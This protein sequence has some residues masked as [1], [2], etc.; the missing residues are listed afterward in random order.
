LIGF[1]VLVA[2]LGPM[3]VNEKQARV[4]AA[5]PNLP[6][7]AEYAFG[8]DS[9]GRDVFTT[10]ILAIPPTLRIGLI[11]GVISVVLGLVLGLSAGF[12]RGWADWLIRTFSDVL[13]AV[14]ALA[15][16][17]LIVARME[18][19]NIAVV[20]VIVGFLT[21]SGTARGIRSMV[22]SIR[23]R[24]YTAVARANGESEA[25]VLFREIMPNLLPIMLASFI[26]A[27]SMGIYTVMSLEVLGLG[28]NVIPSLG[29]MI[30]WSQRFSA[31]LRG[32]YWWWGPPIFTIALIFIGLFFLSF[33]LDRFINPAIPVRRGL[34]RGKRSAAPSGAAAPSA[35][36]APAEAAARDAVLEIRN[37]RVIY[38]TAGGVVK[39]VDDVS[40]SLRPGE[41]MGLIG[42]SGSGKTTMATAALRL[43]RPP[44]YIIGGQILL[45]GRDLLSLPDR[46]LI[47]LRL[48]EIALM[49]QAAMNSLNPVVRVGPQFADAIAAHLGRLPRKQ[50][51]DMV[52]QA[53]AKVGLKPEVVRR[54][55][56]Q[57]SGG[58]KQ[59]TAMAIA[60]ILH[61][62][63]I[64]ADEPTSALDVVVQQQVMATLGRL[65]QELGAAVLLIGHD[66]GLMTQFADSV[67]V[68]YAGKLVERGDVQAVLDNPLHPYTRMLIDSLPTLDGKRALVGIPGLPPELL[69]LPGGCAFHPRCPFAMQRC[70]DETPA[71]QTPLPGR[72]V[73][74]HLYPG[75]DR[76]P[77]LAVQIDGATA[78]GV[79]VATNASA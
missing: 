57:L 54:F 42:E 23:E 25:E 30:F 52:T 33:G 43:T 51:D 45:E 32:M 16:M 22:L 48:K 27:V 29:M 5:E 39:A 59:R 46:E 6:P 63:V 15:F 20:A 44:A 17:I 13:M 79:E 71:L 55:P 72:Q 68:L 41:R 69:K 56:H 11:A 9:Q 61:P 2:L 36:A 70:R 14:P 53:L 62:K 7:S 26:G 37:L 10:L 28:S 73:A 24:S 64:I 58:M 40:F 34:A 31:V 74:C 67:G 21:W 18:R 50:V 38:E 8:T 35:A 47:R 78:A 66:M 76:L 4:G 75:R 49:P 77:Q 1:M 12:F 60:T 65:Q 3:L 19:P